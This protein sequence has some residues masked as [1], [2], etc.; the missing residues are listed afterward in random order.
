MYRAHYHW[1]A[2]IVRVPTHTVTV[3]C[4]WGLISMP[5]QL[6]SYWDRK[7]FRRHNR[8][9]RHSTQVLFISPTILSLSRCLSHIP[10]AVALTQYY[11][12][13]LLFTKIILNS[14]GLKA[15][16]IQKNHFIITTSPHN[17][18][19]IIYVDNHF[20]SQ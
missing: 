8:R 10:N 17:F 2:K 6:R 1:R 16:G 11:S 14:L 13:L 3:H 20:L 15:F 19:S 5:S 18:T 12:R 4:D 9:L 7:C